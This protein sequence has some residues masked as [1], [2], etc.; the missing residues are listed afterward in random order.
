[1]K[2][3]LNFQPAKTGIFRIITTPY[4]LICC[5]VILIF[6]QGTDASAQSNQRNPIPDELIETEMFHNAISFEEQGRKAQVPQNAVV[7]IVTIDGTPLQFQRIRNED[8][9][10]LELTNPKGEPIP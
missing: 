8:E 5:F 9:L 10:T 4:A 3:V 2:K 7:E 6:L 1:M